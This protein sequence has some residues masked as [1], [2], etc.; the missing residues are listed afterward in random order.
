MLR[1]HQL[2]LL[3]LLLVLVVLLVLLLLLLLLLFMLLQLMLLLVLLLLGLAVL[4]LQCCVLGHLVHLQARDVLG[5]LSAAVRDRTSCD[6]NLHLLL[7][8][9]C[10]Q[11]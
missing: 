11:I 1:F 6:R 10:A 9:Q 8:Q 2:L 5:Q 4:H 3:M 7:M